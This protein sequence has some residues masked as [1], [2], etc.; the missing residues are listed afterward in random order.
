MQ[1]RNIITPVPTKKGKMKQN[2]RITHFLDFQEFLSI[3]DM[4]DQYIYVVRKNKYKIA[5]EPA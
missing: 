3:S 5:G 1:S 4:I 2:E